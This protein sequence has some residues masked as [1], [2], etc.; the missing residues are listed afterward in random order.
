MQLRKPERIF[1]EVVC[2]PVGSFI[3]RFLIMSDLARFME[4]YSIVVTSI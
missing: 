2:L 3:A 1:R 4:D